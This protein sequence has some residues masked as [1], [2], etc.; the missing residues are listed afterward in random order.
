[1]CGSL[2]I[3]RQC[4]NSKIVQTSRV[5]KLKTSV[6][7]KATQ[8]KHKSKHCHR[9]FL[10]HNALSIPWSASHIRSGD[11]L[12]ASL[13]TSTDLLFKCAC[14]DSS[15]VSCR[16]KLRPNASIR[17]WQQHRTASKSSYL[18][19]LRCVSLGTC[20]SQRLLYSSCYSP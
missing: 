16:V 9:I 2:R 8:L 20:A 4:I 1:M 14:S 11:L 15:N 12:S 3:L 10:L 6:N 7:S 19:A 17:C 18:K 5:S 13:S